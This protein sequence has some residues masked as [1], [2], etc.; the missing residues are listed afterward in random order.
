MRP[1]VPMIVLETALLGVL[2]CMTAP[3]HIRATTIYKPDAILVLFVLLTFL[4]CLEAAEKGTLGSYLLAGMGVGLA[5]A[6]KQTGAFASIPLV[7]A[8]ILGWRQ[9]ARWLWL[10]AALSGQDLYL[11]RG[12]NPVAPSAC[13]GDDD[14]RPWTP[15]RPR[16]QHDR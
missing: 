15:R 9:A 16:T 12:A 8:T 11:R 7:T 3:V 6:S 2:I 13:R 1:G 4:W 10:G 14:L 5:S